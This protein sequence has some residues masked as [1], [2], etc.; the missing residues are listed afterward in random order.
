MVI[1]I[2]SLLLGSLLIGPIPTSNTQ[3]NS[4]HTLLRLRAS[5]FS[6][7]IIPIIPVYNG[8]FFL[9]LP[10]CSLFFLLK[11]N[12]RCMKRILHLFQSKNMFV[13]TK[14]MA[15]NHTFLRTCASGCILET[16]R[17]CLVGRHSRMEYKV[18]NSL[19]PASPSPSSLE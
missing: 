15:A 11:I 9:K 6:N 19:G 17:R 7:R 3:T 8:T 10:P 5:N 16:E 14:A 12:L 18:E 1:C 2:E 13:L 4:Q